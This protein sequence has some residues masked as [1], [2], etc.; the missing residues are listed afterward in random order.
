M[1]IQEDSGSAFILN[2]RHLLGWK[3]KRRSWRKLCRLTDETGAA[4]KKELVR[5]CVFVC[6]C[7]RTCGVR[8]ARV[9]Q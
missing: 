2:F 7:A 9:C 3:E 8:A 4:V 1:E 6:V 5:V